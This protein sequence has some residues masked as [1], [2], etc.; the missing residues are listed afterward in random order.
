LKEPQQH[1]LSVRR[2][3]SDLIHEQGAAIE[4]MHQSRGTVHRTRKGATLMTEEL[5]AQELSR[6]IGAVQD[7]EGLIAPSAQAL[8]RSYHQLFPGS[9][10][11]AD[12]HRD[13]G[14]RDPL[15]LGEQRPHHWAAPNDPVK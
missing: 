9:R 2:Q 14:R 8:D 6:K 12:Q 15:D 11:P 5:T 10:L 13:I 4:P 7:L 3:L 1:R